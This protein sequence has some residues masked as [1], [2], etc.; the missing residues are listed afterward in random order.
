MLNIVMI[1][2][3][4]MTDETDHEHPMPYVPKRKRPPRFIRTDIIY[5][6][7]SSSWQYIKHHINNMKVSWIYPK[8]VKFKRNN[9]GMRKGSRSNICWLHCHMHTMTTSFDRCMC[10]APFNSDSHSIMFGN[11]ASASVMNNLKDFTTTPTC[12]KCNVKG[13]SSNAQVT[14]KGTVKWK[15][16]DNHGK[17][18][19][20]IIPDSFYI[21]DKNIVPST[22]CSTSQGS[23]TRSQGN[24]L[25]H[26]KFID[27]I[28]LESKEVL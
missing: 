21:A 15:L 26:Y 18:H 9:K 24:R 7:M 11:G 23:Q 28:I 12:I 8:H 25:Y 4:I 22:L 1:T 6:G 19:E 3:I 10:R 5:K 17:I 20:L 13:I 2:M 27:Q 16:E 14:F